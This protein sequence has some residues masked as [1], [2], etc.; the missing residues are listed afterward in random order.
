MLDS[1]VFTLIILVGFLLVLVI[2]LFAVTKW[3][4][5]VHKTRRK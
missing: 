1:S 3:L 5:A 2:A 4:K